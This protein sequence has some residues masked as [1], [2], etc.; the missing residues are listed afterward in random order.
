MNPDVTEEIE[1]IQ[2]IYDIIVNFLVNYSFQLIG[3]IFVFL[4]GSFLAKKVAGWVLQLCTAKK[5]DITLSEF[6]ANVVK[7]IIM[8]MI[9]I[10]C[11]NML[12]ISITPFIA[13]IGALSL[14]AGLAIQGVLSNFGSGFN[15][16]LTRPFVVGDTIKVQGVTG[17]VLKIN[18]AF[19]LLQNEDGMNIMVP[20][21]HIV[22][23]ILHNSGDISLLELSVGVSY[24]SD[25]D[26]VIGY[27]KNAV[28][29]MEVVKA[30]PEVQVGIIEFADSSVSLEVRCWVD[31]QQLATSKHQVNKVI[32]DTLNEHDVVIPFPQREVSL[33][34]A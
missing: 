18:L 8:T 28:S 7:I 29:A 25:L 6:I 34:Q 11:L 16:I 24:S 31:S 23:E 32:W 3:A 9:A 10:M 30:E 27:L 21:R 19:T 20:N 4:I 26:A 2:K 1:Q 13:A 15:I 14:G 17:V 12:G 33:K 5:L 22:G